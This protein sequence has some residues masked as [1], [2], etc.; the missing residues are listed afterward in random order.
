MMIRLIIAF[1]ILCSLGVSSI[2]ALGDFTADQYKKA[3][4][5]T[6]RFYGGQRSGIG[7][8][9]L[10]MEHTN[11][12]YRTCFTNDKDGDY[13]LQGGWF[14]CGD[15]VTF[16]QTFFYSAYVLAKAYEAFPTG[17]HDL[18]HGNDYSDFKSS[19]N[20]DIG[21]GKPNGIPDILEE[22]KYAT[23]WIIRATPNGTTFYSQKGNGDYDHKQWV[24]AGKM[25]SLSTE[26]GGEPRP[27]TKNPNDGSM[28][29]FAA[30]TLAVMSR[31]YKVCDS[32]YADTCLQ[33]AKNAYTY[34]KSHK[35]QAVGAGGY[36]GTKPNPAADFVAAAA[37]M[38]GVTK[39]ESYKSDVTANM[40][41]LKDHY[42]TFCYANSD[43]IAYYA[44]ATN[45]KDSTK[46]KELKTLF[47]D[48]Y[49][50]AGTGEAGLG[51]IGD[52]WGFLRYPAN[53]AF[54][55]ALYAKANNT[56][57]Y[58]NF[59][60]NQIDYILGS[61]DAKKSFVV[62][63]QEG[64]V[65]SSPTLPHHR[66]VYLN[67]N[68]DMKTL[69]GIP[70]RNKQFGYMVG[71]T[72][73]SSSSFVEAVDKYTQTEGGIDYNAGLV[74]ALGYILSK[75][76][77]ADTTVM[78]NISAVCSQM[79]TAPVKGITLARNGTQY[80]FSSQK[81]NKIASVKIL[82]LSG[83]L[84]FSSVSNCGTVTWAHETSHSNVL[85]AVVKMQNGSCHSIKLV[86]VE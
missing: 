16:G 9:W 46:M 26:E 61:N 6:T 27:I 49:K 24:T 34:A 80:V 50:N 37:E 35:G 48:R 1:M 58:D 32:A 2:S 78:F 12:E 45:L 20:W 18:Y 8:N 79:A 11:P 67:D 85:S 38:Y 36:Y 10:I 3:A 19:S 29:A 23:D 21:G 55:A 14:D 69:N 64:T 65:T 22:L 75:S 4:W 42:Y 41:S 52:G 76:V 47:V 77:P 66:C 59:I 57:D 13:N 81:G 33:H 71:F 60:Y 73:G 7:P 84:V 82:S 28:A 39:D 40:G 56:T 86:N 5:M 54:I 70:A 43:D 30:A 44:V 31:V 17:F 72:K 62:G 83:K 51:T 74:G 15:H 63:F 53:Q 68:N 25:S